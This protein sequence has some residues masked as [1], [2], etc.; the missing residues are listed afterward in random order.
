MAQRSS[1]GSGV[2]GFALILALLVPGLSAAEPKV[3]LIGTWYVLIHYRDS[4]TANPDSD[5]WEDKIWRFQMKGTRLSWTDYPIVVFADQ[6]GRFGPVAGNP[7]AR[8]MHAWE[9]NA[10]QQQEIE[11]GLQVNDRGSKTKSLRG[12]PKKGY[13]S[14]GAQRSVSAATVGYQQIWSIDDPTGLPVFTRDDSL[15]TEA[16]LAKKDKDAVLSG[17]TRFTTTSVSED[18]NELRG[19][20]VRDENRVGSFRLLRVAEPRG[21]ESD[22]RTPNEKASD[23][24]Q[25]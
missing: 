1:I 10:A 21:L 11:A 12:S 4:Y 8:I 17:R 3:D 2:L 23:R 6:T 14:F 16:A 15:G 13:K 5:R 9:P 22:G 7:R 24:L 25:Y 19:D 18:G 20:F